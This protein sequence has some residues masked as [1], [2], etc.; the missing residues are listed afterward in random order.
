LNGFIVP[1]A[2][3]IIDAYELGFWWIAL[4]AADALLYGAGILELSS[5]W[6]LGLLAAVDV[7]GLLL[8]TYMR[9]LPLHGNNI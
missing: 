6:V 1:P 3:V 8:F 4:V 5:R 9:R 2:A 7:G